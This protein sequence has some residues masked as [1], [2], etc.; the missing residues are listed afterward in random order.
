ML[1]LNNDLGRVC[2]GGR[3]A[4]PDLNHFA[5]CPKQS[6]L[7]CGPHSILPLPVLGAN[8]DYFARLLTWP[9]KITIHLVAANNKALPDL[10]VLQQI[11]WLTNQQIFNFWKLTHFLWVSVCDN[12]WR[13]S[14]NTHHKP[15]RQYDCDGLPATHCKYTNHRCSH[16]LCQSQYF[17]MWK[18]FSCDSPPC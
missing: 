16:L 12:F 4:A 8:C 9:A 10:F 14:P 7:N 15:S 1:A 2:E 11:S 13:F 6:P 5:I 3:N 17:H 18:Y